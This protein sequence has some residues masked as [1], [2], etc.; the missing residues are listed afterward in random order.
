MP[1]VTRPR[2][3]VAASV[4]SLAAALGGT[5]AAASFPTAGQPGT[6]N[7]SSRSLAMQGEGTPGMQGEATP[8]MQGE[9]T[10]GMQGEGGTS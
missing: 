4:L 8:G 1:R 3:M 2:I 10:P 5:A 9:A 6:Q 7:Q